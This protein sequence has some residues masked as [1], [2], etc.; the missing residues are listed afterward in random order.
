MIESPGNCLTMI[1][2]RFFVYGTERI[3]IENW[4]G[5]DKYMYR[6]VSRKSACGRST[7]QVCERGEW[8]PFQVFLHLTT[9]ERP[10]DVYSNSMPLKHR[11]G[12]TITYN[13]AASGFK[14]KSW[15]HTT[16]WKAPSLSPWAW[17]SSLCTPHITSVYTKQPRNNL[18]WSITRSLLPQI[19]CPSQTWRVRSK[20]LAPGWAL[21]WANFD[22]IQEIGPKVGGGRSFVRLQYMCSYA[23]TTYVVCILY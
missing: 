11:I 8:T 16:L 4:H 10:C 21:I 20:T 2:R 15:W 1:L 18:Q 12:Q 23:F 7:L 13:R 5:L 3:V 22:P 9:K 19:G 17:R 14:V 6:I